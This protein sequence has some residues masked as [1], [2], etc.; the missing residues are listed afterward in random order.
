[1]KSPQ[2]LLTICIVLFISSI[3]CK[4]ATAKQIH[5]S[6]TAGWLESILLQPG[7]IKMRAKLDTGA[8][9]SSLHAI[10]IKRFE[11][12]GEQ[13]ISFRTGT[14]EMVQINSPLVRDVKIKDHKLK[15]V[16]RPVVEMKFC[17][18]NQIFTSEF[19]LIDRSRF[20][21]PILLG[22]RLLQQGIIVDPSLTFTVRS[23]KEKCEILLNT[24]EK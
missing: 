8:K 2:K 23:D 7:N 4:L 14:D 5:E 15:A 12:Y 18:H 13:W 22:R 3:S 17:L 20:N 16:V 24:D 6:I 19:S 10:D 1:M 21:Y 11:R 9:T